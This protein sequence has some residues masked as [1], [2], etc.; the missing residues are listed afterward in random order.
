MHV[1]VLSWM[2]SRLIAPASDTTLLASNPSLGMLLE[3]TMRLGPKKEHHN[4][5]QNAVEG[6]CMA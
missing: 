2:N 5:L 6:S 3:V 1:E 4:I